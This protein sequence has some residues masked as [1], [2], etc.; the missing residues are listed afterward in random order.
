MTNDLLCVNVAATLTLCILG[1]IQLA[2]V[3]EAYR[4]ANLCRYYLGQILEK[5]NQQVV[6]AE[7]VEPAEEE[8]DPDWWKKK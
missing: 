1:I 2:V 6:E 5:A 3:Y 7:A 8:D 4:A